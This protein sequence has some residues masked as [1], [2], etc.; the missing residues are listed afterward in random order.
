M[1]SP[2]IH[3]GGEDWF[4]RLPRG[5]SNRLDLGFDTLLDNQTDGS[6]GITAKAAIRYRVTHGFRLEAGVGSSDQGDGKAVNADFAAVIAN[7]TASRSENR[8]EPLNSW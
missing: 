5:M 7:Y 8:R 6:L 3:A 2:C 4:V 1:P